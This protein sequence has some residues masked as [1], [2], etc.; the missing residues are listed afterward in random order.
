MA[1]KTKKSNA[2]YRKLSPDIVA[3]ICERAPRYVHND[4]I[5][6]A[7]GVTREQVRNST[8]QLMKAHPEYGVTEVSPYVYAWSPPVEPA[9]VTTLNAQD[10]EKQ[11]SL[12][13]M[14]ARRP[15]TELTLRVLAA[16]PTKG[17]AVT[18]ILEDA[19]DELWIARKIP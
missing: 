16:V 3:H 1:P 8:R 11:V 13:Q 9:T 17:E 19:S 6:T 5:A 14:T 2:G 12:E 18:L 15:P 7:L 10:D 4:D